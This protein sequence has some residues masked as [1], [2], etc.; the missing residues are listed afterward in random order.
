MLV[1]KS[2]KEDFETRRQ[3]EEELSI[4]QESRAQQ[5]C[6]YNGGNNHSSIPYNVW[7]VEN[8]SKT[9]N[10]HHIHRGDL[11]REGKDVLY[12][13]NAV[14]K[15]GARNRVFLQADPS[16]TVDY[17]VW[18]WSPLGLQL[19]TNISPHIPL[20]EQI[21]KKYG[22]NKPFSDFGL[23][24]PQNEIKLWSEKDVPASDS[25][26]EQTEQAPIHDGGY[27]VT[28]ESRGYF[29][30]RRISHNRIVVLGNQQKEVALSHL[31]DNKILVI[32]GGPG[33][34][35]TSTMI[36]RLKLLLSSG[37]YE[38]N[39]G[40]ENTQY[41]RGADWDNL[42][43]IWSE[44]LKNKA[45]SNNVWM[46][47]SPTSQ[48]NHF[49][50]K[51][52]NAEGLTYTDSTT[53]VWVD[54][55]DPDELS[56]YCLTLAEDEYHLKF[57]R[58][59]CEAEDEYFHDTPLNLYKSFEK[60]LFDQYKQYLTPQLNELGNK[61]RSAYGK[62]FNELVPAFENIDSYFS[63]TQAG[64]NDTYELLYKHDPALVDN[65]INSEV[66][67]IRQSID[68]ICNRIKENGCE[69]SNPT[70][71]WGLLIHYLKQLFGQNQMQQIFKANNI[72]SLQVE[73]FNNDYKQFEYAISEAAIRDIYNLMRNEID[74][75]LK[76]QDKDDKSKKQ[77]EKDADRKYK[78]DRLFI[79]PK[80]WPAE[81]KEK[82]IE[83][84]FE[85]IESHYPNVALKYDFFKSYFNERRGSNESI[86]LFLEKQQYPLD[87]NIYEIAFR[88]I[89]ECK[90]RKDISYK[91]LGQTDAE[92]K[93]EFE[94][95]AKVFIREIVKNY[96]NDGK[97]DLGEAFLPNWHL[98]RDVNSKWAPYREVETCRENIYNKDHVEYL[99]SI[100][101]KKVYEEKYREQQGFNGDIKIQE[102]SFLIFAGNTLARK[103]YQNNKDLFEQLYNKEIYSRDAQEC[104]TFIRAYK[105]SCRVVIG[106]DEATDFTPIELAAL[107]SL[108]HPEYSCITLSGDQM[109]AF[110]NKGITNWEQLGNGIFEE[111][112][113]VKSLNISYRQTPALLNMAKKIYKRVL[114]TEAPYRP[115]VSSITSEA[116]PLL[117]QSDNDKEKQCW[118]LERLNLVREHLGYLPATAIFYPDDDQS[119][120]E[121]FVKEINRNRP[122]EV[123]FKVYS[124]FGNTDDA[125]VIVYPLSLVKGLEFETAFFY[126]LDNLEDEFLLQQYLYVGLSRSTFYLAAT[127][128]PQW[129]TDLSHD[130]KTDEREANWPV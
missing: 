2:F 10:N 66:E 3:R 94:S 40:Y 126:N 47:F 87:E 100:L 77:S 13:Q 124:C 69:S 112:Y 109:Q 14:T 36:Q 111:E 58:Q 81:D 110:N 84:A 55:S 31:F 41:A 64:C 20:K 65:F 83:K 74:D 12:E 96:I 34:G 48:L 79:A 117:K 57:P 73:N 38:N 103:L 91:R 52:L 90:K 43:K 89:S 16:I 72:A 88:A 46:F 67:T 75:E 115:N 62:D 85:E 63:K 93:Q 26:E 102:V 80:D 24:N 119:E 29:E 129:N 5:G 32:D 51:S 27:D 33:T 92:L 50:Q 105:D 15:M 120:I 106:I 113:D 107:A 123:T 8:I 42:Q 25:K 7:L 104:C 108:K 44:F 99:F 68:G 128:S 86:E 56:G 76:K 101:L 70:I 23:V 121:R 54:R 19:F 116:F 98:V 127:S 30:R 125:K 11:Y 1:G 61:I 28:D 37:L 39:K 122:K 17:E 49:L 118:I 130:F 114:K 60:T 71:A 21:E 45:D 82:A 22:S 18:K 59:S 35:K 6:L 78:L 95:F 4:Q 9:L 53:N 97:K